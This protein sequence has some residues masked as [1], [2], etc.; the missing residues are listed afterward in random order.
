MATILCVEDEM[1]LR[2]D[3]VEELRGAGHDV[4]EAE[5]GEK[6]LEAILTCRP[7]LVL[8]DITMPVM[9]GYELMRAIRSEHPEIAEM[10][11]I[12]LSA[13]AD[14]Q[15]IVSGRKLG[16]DDYLVKPIDYDLLL[17]TV[18]SRLAS[19]ARMKARKEDQLVRLYTALTTTPPTGAKEEERE[20]V[21]RD[22]LAVTMVYPDSFD[23]SPVRRLLELQGYVVTKFDRGM[24]FI[25]SL[26]QSPP[27][28]V[29]LAYNTNDLLAPLLVKLAKE[30]YDVRFPIVLLTT[31]LT[32]KALTSSDAQLFDACLTF[33]CDPAELIGKV[34]ALTSKWDKPAGHPPQNS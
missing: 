9:N 6:G 8:S 23:L 32:A 19:I 14:K 24:D 28:A 18:E 22:E 27:G 16:A 17:A 29:L 13:L 33:P 15:H 30:K 5:N 4:I 21:G 12:F 3:I 25:R 20:K 26:E 7:D 34:E 11:F 10:P 31:P 2:H 1:D